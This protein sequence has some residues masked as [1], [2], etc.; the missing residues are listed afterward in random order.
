MP[1]GEQNGIHVMSHCTVSIRRLSAEVDRP[2]N[3]IRIRFGTVVV[4]RR[5]ASDVV[6]QQ[7]HVENVFPRASFRSGRAGLQYLFPA[8]PAGGPATY[9]CSRLLMAVQTHSCSLRRECVPTYEY[10]L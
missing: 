3:K 8:G 1:L 4:Q 10:Y 6:S 5:A 2:G 9:T 7:T